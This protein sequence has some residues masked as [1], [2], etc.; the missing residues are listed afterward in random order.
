MTELSMQHR[1][2]PSTETDLASDTTNRFDEIYTTFYPQI[3]R[4]IHGREV[5]EDAEDI[6]QEAFIKAFTH[7]DTYVD[8]GLQSAWLKRIA[9]NTLIDRYRRKKSRGVVFTDDIE[10]LDKENRDPGTIQDTPVELDHSRDEL[11]ATIIATVTPD[12]AKIFSLMIDGYNSV[13]ISEILSVPQATVLT[14]IHRGRK[15]L[16]AAGILPLE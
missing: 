15:A 1:D 13:E 12:Q 7:L 2:I 10:L 6:A 11:L 14:R 9:L 4:F 3:V 5:H 8:A 16:K